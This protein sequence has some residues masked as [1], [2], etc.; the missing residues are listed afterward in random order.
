[1]SSDGTHYA[2]GGG[3]FHTRNFRCGRP[4][5]GLPSDLSPCVR[6]PDDSSRIFR[7]IGNRLD[8]LTY[9]PRFDVDSL[10]SR[11][12][13]LRAIRLRGCYGFEPKIFPPTPSNGESPC[14]L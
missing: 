12:A 10:I 3:N 13:A 5:S 8:G 1:M 9:N 14:E 7:V 11:G 4:A 2:R 6:P